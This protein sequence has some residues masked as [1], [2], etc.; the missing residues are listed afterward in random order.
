MIKAE[1]ERGIRYLCH[2]WRKAEGL[3]QTEQSKLS[4]YCF[5]AWV[6]DHHPAYLDFR[7]STSITD[8][9]ERWFESEFRQTAWR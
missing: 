8:D 1:A 5:L 2:E 9:V 3:Q 4:F 7:T 6:R